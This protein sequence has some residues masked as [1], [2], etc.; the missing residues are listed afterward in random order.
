MSTLKDKFVK[1][2]TFEES[3]FQQLHLAHQANILVYARVDPREGHSGH[4]G[5]ASK[6]KELA[7][8]LRPEFGKL[9]LASQT[10]EC[11][12]LMRTHDLDEASSA[13][14]VVIMDFDSNSLRLL[15][16]INKRPKQKESAHLALICTVII[17]PT[18]EADNRTGGG[19]GGV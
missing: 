6:T 13:I 16:M 3:R 15:D 8:K 2:L 7:R 17:L 12:K 9:Y 5:H 18:E 1:D 4:A 14:D 10:Q 19:G 11:F